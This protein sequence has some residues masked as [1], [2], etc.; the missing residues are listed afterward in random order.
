MVRTGIHNVQV[1]YK[2]SDTKIPVRI[3]IKGNP[4]KQINLRITTSIHFNL[5]LGLLL[6][7]YFYFCLLSF[8][9]C[10]RI[11]PLCTFVCFTLYI[12]WPQQA[13]PL[14]CLP[15]LFLLSPFLLRSHLLLLFYFL[16]LHFLLFPTSFYSIYSHYILLSIWHDTQQEVKGSTLP[17]EPYQADSFLLLLVLLY[18]FTFFPSFLLFY[19]HYF[20]FHNQQV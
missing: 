12:M 15:L 11:F 19:S 9:S 20:Y 10:Q 16:L 2:H 6:C 17:Q 8:Y 1:F 3:T 13:D 18:L 14:S 5:D 4:K 7:V